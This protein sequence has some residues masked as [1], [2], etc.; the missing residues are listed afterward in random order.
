MRNYTPEDEELK[1]RQVPKAKP[2]SGEH[3]PPLEDANT[4]TQTDLVALCN[5]TFG[6]VLSTFFVF[7]WKIK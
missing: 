2:A 7:Q 5:G 4:S 3:L 6:A 1:D